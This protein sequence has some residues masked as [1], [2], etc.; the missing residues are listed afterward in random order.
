MPSKQPGYRSRRSRENVEVVRH[1]VEN[2]NGGDLD[3][4]LESF[5]EEVVLRTAEGWPE[6]AHHGKLAARSFY[7]GWAEKVGGDAVIED[8][9]DAGEAVV[10]RARAH[11]TGERSGLEGDMKFSQ[12]LTFRKGK[13]VLVE[14]FWDHQEALEA[15]GLE[16]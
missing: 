1:A 8:L 11:M 15:A 7:E 13:V 6:R 14:F 12:V 4:A 2:W 16:E 3:A 5:D 10:F 9:I